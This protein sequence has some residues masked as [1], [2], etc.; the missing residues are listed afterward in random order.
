MNLYLELYRVYIFLLG[1]DLY[2]IN[3]NDNINKNDYNNNSK[4]NNNSNYNNINK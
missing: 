1:M 3:D 2:D 4:Y